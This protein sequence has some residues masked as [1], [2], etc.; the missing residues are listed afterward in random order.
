MRQSSFVWQS[1]F[2]ANYADPHDA[3]LVP[4]LKKKPAS[5][6]TAARTT[7]DLA[8]TSGVAGA[9]LAFIHDG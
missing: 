1:A 3:S 5:A 6:N 2:D 9:T 7:P 8:K 4:D